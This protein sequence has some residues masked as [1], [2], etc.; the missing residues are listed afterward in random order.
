[1]LNPILFRVEFYSRAW[2][3]RNLIKHFP[4][5]DVEVV[6]GK[7]AKRYGLKIAK[8][9]FPKH[10]RIYITTY[11][12]PASHSSDQRKKT[13][14]TIQRRKKRKFKETGSTG[15]RTNYFR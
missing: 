4:D 10:K 1:M 7:V 6:K 5:K 9:R 12:Y 11:Q 8:M 15:H 14:R 13:F 2:A 3:Q